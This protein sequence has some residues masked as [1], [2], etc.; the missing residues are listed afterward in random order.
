[1]AFTAHSGLLKFSF[2]LTVFLFF[3]GLVALGSLVKYAT[4]TVQ[5]S[6]GDDYKVCLIFLSET[7][8]SGM[9]TFADTTS[10]LISVVAACLFAMDFVTWKKSENYK[11][12]RASIASLFL[13][14]GMCI[15]SF[16]AAI[17]LALGIKS[18]MNH[19]ED[20]M[21]GSTYPGLKGIYTGISCVALGGLFF[22]IYASSEYVQYRRRHIN[23]DKVR[24]RSKEREMTA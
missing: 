15:L 10:A 19:A 5:L 23:G 6:N 20:V 18:T 17:T 4:Q 22:G 9:C 8:R 3:C 16:C 1:M 24:L 11:G 21:P 14:P 12:K 2:I 7:Q 13:A